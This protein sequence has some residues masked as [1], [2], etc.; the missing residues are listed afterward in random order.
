MKFLLLGSSSKKGLCQLDGY[1]LATSSATGEPQN[2][3]DYWQMTAPQLIGL[4]ADL[5]KTLPRSAVFPH[6]TDFTMRTEAD[7]KPKSFAFKTRAGR[8]GILQITGFTDNPRGVKIRYRLVQ[9]QNSPTQKISAFEKT[10][11]LTRATNQ[12]VGTTTD[13][14]TVGVWSEATL[15]PGEKFHQITRLPDGETVNTIASVFSRYKAGK[16]GSST[17]FTWWFKEADGFGATEAEAATAQIRE[18]WTQMPLSFEASVPRE[19]FCVTNGRGAT[20]AGS[21][22]FVHEAPQPLDENGLI[23]TTVQIR[24]FRD[25]ISIPGIG[26]MAKVPA[27][28]TLRATSNYGEGNINSPAGPDDYGVTWLPMNYGTRQASSTTVKWNLQRAPSANAARSPDEPSEKFE[29]VLGRPRLILS[30]T[31]SPDDVFQGFLELVGPDKV[32]KN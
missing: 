23:K 4:F 3:D 16:V 5:E 30:I 12:L 13:T 18:H 21:I 22:E 24:H 29:I 6:V 31:N 26:F 28:Y 14:R 7:G 27:G 1:S 19:M 20:L 2:G 11:M 9:V 25:S 8:M 15:L 17:S 10:I 32:E